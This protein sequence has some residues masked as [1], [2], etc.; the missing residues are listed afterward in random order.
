MLSHVLANDVRET[1]FRDCSRKGADRCREPWI[2]RAPLRWPGALA[3]PRTAVHSE[4]SFE[5][6]RQRRCGSPNQ[7]PQIERPRLSRRQLAQSGSPLTAG[8][9]ANILILCSSKPRW[10][11]QLMQEVR[12]SSIRRAPASGPAKAQEWR[13]DL[14]HPE[15]LRCFATIP[16]LGNGLQFT[17]QRGG[18]MR[19]G[20][21]T[22]K[23]ERSE[24]PDR[25]ESDSARPSADAAAACRSGASHVGRDCQTAWT[26]GAER[27]RANGQAGYHSRLVP[28]PDCAEV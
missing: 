6:C 1:L 9:H 12:H 21:M 15:I 10:L 7:S 24:Y 17:L 5:Y 26:Q 27:H 11:L 3:D 18:H 8:D 2:R 13:I 19:I 16:R 25:R 23:K 14:T 28:A 4:G 22:V 20:C